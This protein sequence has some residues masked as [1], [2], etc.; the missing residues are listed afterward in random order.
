M[1]HVRHLV[2]A[3]AIV[4]VAASTPLS[5]AAEPLF[6]LTDDG[7]TFLYRA[8]PGDLPG[9]VAE[10]FGIPARDVPAFLAA[11]GISDPTRVGAGFTYRIPNTTARA[12]G[13]RITSLEGE[14]TSLSRA[15]AAEKDRARGLETAAAEA[16]ATAAEA[17]ARAAR[18]SRLD[19]I[20]PW[21]KIAIVVLLFAAGGAVYTAVTALRRH[22]QVDRYARALARELE[23]KRKSALVERQDSARRVLDLE[24]KVRTLETQIRPRVVVS[25]RGGS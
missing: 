5:A 19:R 20:W 7:K 12:L 18:L 1:P 3:V 2:A 21:A 25:G 15:L 10:M 24:A 6:R 23:E 8:R 14:T 9:I 17:D 4:A 16:R 13:D 22:G 11:N